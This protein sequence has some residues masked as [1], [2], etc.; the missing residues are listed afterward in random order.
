MR[1][2]ISIAIAGLLWFSTY[3]YAQPNKQLYEQQERCG[4]RAAEV[5]KRKY[6]PPV[7]KLE[8]GQMTFRYENHYSSRLSKCF[9]L[10]IANAY[11]RIDGKP[12]ISKRMRLFDLSDNKEYGVFVGSIC[13]GCGPMACSVQDK[14]CQSESEWRQLLKRFMED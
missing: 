4:K 11:E 5:F 3:V 2:S 12:T 14:V 8:H 10:E 9:F 6:S 1:P 7:A 13:D